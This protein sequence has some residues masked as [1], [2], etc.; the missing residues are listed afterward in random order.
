MTERDLLKFQYRLGY[1]EELLQ[2]KYTTF[3]HIEKLDRLERK[4]DE[5]YFYSTEL[6]EEQEELQECVG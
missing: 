4:I 5:W 6:Y 1:Y 3:A 2:K